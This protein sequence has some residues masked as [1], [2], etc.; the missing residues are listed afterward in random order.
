MEGRVSRDEWFGLAATRVTRAISLAPEQPTRLCHPIVDPPMLPHRTD[1]VAARSVTGNG[2]A[3]ND[4]VASQSSHLLSPR[5]DR[6]FPPLILDCI[7]P[8]NRRVEMAAIDH[9]RED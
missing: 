7:R 6:S 2:P 9:P 4:G 1:A 5:P 3:A 8:V